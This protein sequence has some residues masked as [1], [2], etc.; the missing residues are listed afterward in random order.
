MPPG[1]PRRLWA[2]SVAVLYTEGYIV[3]WMPQKQP[4]PAPG[5]GGAGC[6]CRQVINTGTSVVCTATGCK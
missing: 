2:Q 3:S 1:P 5:P 4:A 6:A